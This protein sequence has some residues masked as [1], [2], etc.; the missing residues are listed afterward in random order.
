MTTLSLCLV[1]TGVLTNFCVET[2][3]N[4]LWTP[5]RSRIVEHR[6]WIEDPSRSGFPSK[7]RTAFFLIH[8]NGANILTR[9]SVQRA[10]EALDTVRNVTGYDD[11]CALATHTSPVGVSGNTTCEI[12]GVQ[13]FWGFDARIFRDNIS[14]D[15]DVVHVISNRAFPD[16]LAPT[17]EELLFVGA[18]RDPQTDLLVAATAFNFFLQ[19]PDTGAS[20]EDFEEAALDAMLQLR[21]R[22][23]NDPTSDARVEVVMRRSFDDEFQRAIVKDLPLLPA[24]FLVMSMF[25]AAMF[26]RRNS[27]QS[28]TLLG[29]SAVL[30]VLLAICAG[31]GLL[32]ITGIPFSSVTQIL[33]FV[34]FGIGVDD[35]FIFMGAFRKTDPSSDIHARVQVVV[36]EIGRSITLTTLTSSL[37][38]GLGCL[39][40]VPAVY[41]ACLYAFP[42]ILFVYIYT[43]T[44]FVAAVVRDEERIRQLRQ[45]CVPS[46]FA[47][48]KST[49]E[50]NSQRTSSLQ[51]MSDG[52]TAN[53]RYMAVY[54]DKL[55]S[56]TTRIVVL[57]IFS[58]LFALCAWSTSRM[59]Q[60]FIL[61]DLMPGDSYVKAYMEMRDKLN[62][63]GAVAPYLYFR[64]ANQSDPF[65]RGQ[66]DDYVNEMVA[67]VDGISEQPQFFWI[68]DF[69]NFTETYSGSTENLS[70]EEQL[71]VFLSVPEFNDL[72]SADITR[73]PNGTILASRVRLF[74]DGVSERG[75]IVSQTAALRQ[76]REISAMAPINSGKGDWSF[77]SY[78]DLYNIWEFYNVSVSELAL[79]TVASVVAV[80]VTALLFIPHWSAVCFILPLISVLYIDLIGVMQWFGV[81]VNAL[82]YV[83]L[84]MS[85]GLMVDFLVHTLDHY[86]AMPGNPREKTIRMLETVGVSVLEGG[87]ST[88]LG[89]LLL[90]FS[91]SEIFFTIFLTFLALVVLGICHGLVLLPV[92]LATFGP[93]SKKISVESLQVLTE[94]A[95][96]VSATT[97]VEKVINN[98]NDDI[99]N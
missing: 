56:R 73:L 79:T 23:K 41:W 82:S 35:I 1:L 94:F 59:E 87:L 48:R 17:D 69:N 27:L 19:L 30:S 92:L 67:N 20:A 77:F 47:C 97:T 54:A 70:F 37:A 32:F 51:S 72:Y 11:L 63:L 52:E 7:P 49:D 85:I 68:R 24:V 9:D 64:L 36:E 53:D 91:S 93:G 75:S 88:L 31:Y 86:F 12:Y 15:Q 58:A 2:R 6:E 99:S 39:S 34:V 40:S 95:D 84:V 14:T 16:T 78:D 10:F 57:V 62:G 8:R 46:C 76:Q 45:D 4:V 65:I 83:T 25:T 18:Q 55:L 42:T 74:M 13:R 43:L 50:E 90:G 29:F 81:R 44:F 38:F 21:E 60:E 28:R 33:I 98:N 66:M 26:F 5:Q 61:T 71:D 80:S 22:W 89:T 96:K 3:S